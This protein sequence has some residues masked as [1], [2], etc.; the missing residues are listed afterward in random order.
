MA[1]RLRLPGESA[2]ASQIAKFETEHQQQHSFES[3]RRDS[4][5]KLPERRELPAESEQ[6]TIGYDPSPNSTYNQPRRKDTLPSEIRFGEVD[7][8]HE[9]QTEREADYPLREEPAPPSLPPFPSKSFNNS[10]SSRSHVPN[11]N[12]PPKQSQPP[13]LPPQQA[14]ANSRAASDESKTSNNYE[15]YRAQQPQASNGNRLG[16]IGGVRMPF[17]VPQPNQLQARNSSS[18]RVINYA[19]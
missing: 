9:Q 8:A 3:R 18:S 6:E 7:T 10:M 19:D 2:L 12:L 5:P 14:Y 11:Y 17:A 13:K 16:R 1:P 15:N 4:L